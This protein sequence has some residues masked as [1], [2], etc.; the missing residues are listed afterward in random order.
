M[1]EAEATQR[2]KDEIEKAQ[3]TKFLIDRLNDHKKLWR[4]KPE[5]WLVEATLWKWNAD[6]KPSNPITI[7]ME[8]VLKHRSKMEGNLEYYSHRDIKPL[9]SELTRY[10]EANPGVEKPEDLETL[11]VQ[12]LQNLR[13]P[14]GA[15]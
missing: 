8:K 12:Y 6:I 3:G 4:Q 15:P 7:E 2:D 14:V 1:D 10:I 11:A 5:N 13:Q 9:I